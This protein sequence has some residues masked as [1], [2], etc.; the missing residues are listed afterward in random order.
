MATKS[1]GA[2]TTEDVKTAI[3]CQALVLVLDEER[4]IEALPHGVTDLDER[5]RGH[6]A[7]RIDGGA[8]VLGLHKPA[9]MRTAS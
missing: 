9:R 1:S 7:A 2:A 3:K 5:R 4:A 6:A 8:R